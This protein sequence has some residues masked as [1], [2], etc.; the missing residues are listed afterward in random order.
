MINNSFNGLQ[1]SQPQTQ[2]NYQNALEQMDQKVR[3][4]KFQD[5][6]EPTDHW[7]DQLVTLAGLKTNQ[8]LF[9]ITL[10]QRLVDHIKQ[11]E[12]HFIPTNQH[13]LLRKSHSQNQKR[14]QFLT[15]RSA[16][17]TPLSTINNENFQSLVNNM[18]Q[19]YEV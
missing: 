8:Q 10:I 7:M 13:H 16:K 15:Q 17:L 18:V 12:I 3:T 1:L 2:L 6:L 9:T 14:S 4:V 11:L 5:A 19:Q